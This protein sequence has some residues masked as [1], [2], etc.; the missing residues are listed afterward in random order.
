M[1]IRDRFSGY[2]SIIVPYV[3]MHGSK[4]VEIHMRFMKRKLWDFMRVAWLGVYQVG[5]YRTL[6]YQSSSTLGLGH[7]KNVVISLLA[8]VLKKGF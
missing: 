1:C 2:P 5:K 4:L 7:S 8:S 3:C 6:Q